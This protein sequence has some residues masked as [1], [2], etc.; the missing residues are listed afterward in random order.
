MTCIAVPNQTEY[1]FQYTEQDN[2]ITYIST[3]I[4]GLDPLDIV[5][6]R[7]KVVQLL[8]ETTAGRTPKRLRKGALVDNTGVILLQLWEQNIAE[9]EKGKVYTITNARV[10][11]WNGHKYLGTTR[12]S[13]ITVCSAG[14]QFSDISPD[15]IDQL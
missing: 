8:A 13:V 1:S 9:V 2:N 11:F 7:G 6:V 4:H 10:G 14:V 15:E 5:N 12:H 3:V